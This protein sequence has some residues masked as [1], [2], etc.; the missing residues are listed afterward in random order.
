VPHVMAIT[1]GGI[2]PDGMTLTPDGILIAANFNAG[3]VLAFDAN[4]HPHGK[5]TVPG[6][7]MVTNV[8][9]GG[10]WLY[11]TE[12]SRGEVWRVRLE[13]AGDKPRKSR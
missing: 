4:G 13:A 11:M 2:G 6:G 3:E 9:I 8:A 5:V 7:L 10:E 12:G 1:S